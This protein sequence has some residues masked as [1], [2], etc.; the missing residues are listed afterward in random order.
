M[1]GTLYLEVNREEAPMV[2]SSLPERI[3]AY[4]LEKNLTA[5]ALSLALG[6]G[7]AAIAEIERR[8]T[9]YSPAM[10]ARI[11]RFMAEA[12]EEQI[13]R[14]RTDRRGKRRRPKITAYEYPTPEET[15]DELTDLQR[16]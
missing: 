7:S 2:D 3:R 16:K 13:A 1:T 8:A 4:R 15:D 12:T 11:E 5:K 14:F 6:C 10:A 9:G